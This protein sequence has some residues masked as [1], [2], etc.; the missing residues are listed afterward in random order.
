MNDKDSLL[1]IN[2]ISNPENFDKLDQ[3]LHAN[4]K[5]TLK[6]V[7]HPIVLKEKAFNEKIKEP[8]G[9]KLIL[10]NPKSLKNE[11]PFQINRIKKI[12]DSN[13]NKSINDNLNTDN[14]IFSNNEILKSNVKNKA[15]KN[16]HGNRLDIN[17]IKN[18]DLGEGN[19]TNQSYFDI[20]ENDFRQENHN[21]PLMNL[22]DKDFNSIYNTSKTKWNFDKNLLDDSGFRKTHI[23]KEKLEINHIPDKPI[24]NF[25]F[26]KIKNVKKSDNSVKITSP[27]QEN[28]ENNPIYKRVN[29]MI[30]I[31]SKENETIRD[32]A[33]EVNNNLYS[34]KSNFNI[35]SEEVYILIKV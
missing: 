17:S 20:D 32:L 12:S 21:N 8:S 24:N 33:N 11:E 28:F 30:F 3:L 18:I 2:S 23:I 15:K 27:R 7:E 16:S 5:K 29:S 6:P 19:D 9:L 34:N 14:R 4:K 26:N 25:N 22:S 31:E 10:N 35:D 1:I 13:H